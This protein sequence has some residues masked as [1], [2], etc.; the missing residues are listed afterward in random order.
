MFGV[1]LL[2]NRKKA[3][4]LRNH[5]GTVLGMRRES[6]PPPKFWRLSS[7]QELEN[8]RRSYKESACGSGEGWRGTHDAY[9]KKMGIKQLGRKWSDEHS[10]LGLQTERELDVV[11]TVAASGHSQRADACVDVS[12]TLGRSSSATCFPCLTT[13]SHFYVFSLRRAVMAREHLQILGFP[14]ADVEG[15]TE[16]AISSLA[17]EAMAVPCMAMVLASLLYSVEGFWKGSE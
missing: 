6:K 7:L 10:T 4:A 12:Q 8:R 3:A 16:S 1:R 9:R 11:D 14:S 13:S 2:S 5:A 17:G 15:L